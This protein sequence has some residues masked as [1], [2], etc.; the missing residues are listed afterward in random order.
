MNGMIIVWWLF[1]ELSSLHLCLNVFGASESLSL[2]EANALSIFLDDI[3][4]SVMR[5][6]LLRHRPQSHQSIVGLQL[7]YQILASYL[8][9]SFRKEMVSVW[10]IH[11]EWDLPRTLGT[12]LWTCCC[13]CCPRNLSFRWSLQH[14]IS[15]LLASQL[16]KNSSDASMA[17]TSASTAIMRK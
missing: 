12:R 14:S 13:C 3:E 6:F 7:S 1:S 10:S 11:T 9:S 16:N 17:R 4:H 5:V 8:V 2:G 15:S